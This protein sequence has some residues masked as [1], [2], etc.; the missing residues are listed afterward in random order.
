ME[1][2]LERYRANLG[3]R[4]KSGVCESVLYGTVQYLVTSFFDEQGQYWL[5]EVWTTTYTYERPLVI[6]DAHM[7]RSLPEFGVM[8]F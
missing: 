6:C 2:M 8:S 1:S 4:F 3:Y 7:T 5:V